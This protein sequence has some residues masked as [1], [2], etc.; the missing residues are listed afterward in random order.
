MGGPGSGRKATGRTTKKSKFH[1]RPAN[2]ST[3]V[4]KY[5]GQFIGYK[6]VPRGKK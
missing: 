3:H 6:M 5:F 2:Q 1:D 4:P